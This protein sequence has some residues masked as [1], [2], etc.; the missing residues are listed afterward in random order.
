MPRKYEKTRK[1]FKM[2]LLSAAVSVSLFPVAAP[3]VVAQEEPQLEEVVVTGS[4]ITRFEG[5]FVAPVLSIMPS[6]WS[7]PVKLT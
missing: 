1:P 6:K 5:D 7:A 2:K 4:R 3:L